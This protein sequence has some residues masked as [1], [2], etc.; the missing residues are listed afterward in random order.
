MHVCCKLSMQCNVL[1]FSYMLIRPLWV[2]AW[3]WIPLLTSREP[4]KSFLA[5]SANLDK[6]KSEAC[7]C[8]HVCTGDLCGCFVVTFSNTS[9]I[10]FAFSWA[11]R[12]CL[13][14]F[15]H[16]L[17]AAAKGTMSAH[18]H[19]KCS[20]GKCECEQKNVLRWHRFP[21]PHIFLLNIIQSQN[22]FTTNQ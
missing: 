11:A 10:F 5:S 8:T 21:S 14:T 3:P 4:V 12:M 15:R 13:Q 9:G 1:P 20:S 2:R 7:V 22:S 6:T 19:G 17:I 18:V 16:G